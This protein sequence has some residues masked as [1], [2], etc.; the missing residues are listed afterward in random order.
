VLPELLV[1]AVN[2]E[3]VAGKNWALANAATSVARTAAG[4]RRNFLIRV[5][6]AA[7]HAT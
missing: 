5:R 1:L 6:S 4:A 7:I 3:L 2:D